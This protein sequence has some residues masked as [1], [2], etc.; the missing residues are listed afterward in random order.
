MLRI[1][2]YY[3][4]S[5]KTTLKTQKNDGNTIRNQM[6]IYNSKMLFVYVPV[7]NA[8]GISVCKNIVILALVLKIELKLM[9][10][11]NLYH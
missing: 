2:V 5:V 1:L 4:N 6:Q 7:C 8:W 3:H 11:N 9:Q 10:F